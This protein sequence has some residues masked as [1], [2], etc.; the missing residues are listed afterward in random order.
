MMDFG[1]IK[2]MRWMA[3]RARKG[4]AVDAPYNGNSPDRFVRRI[5]DASNHLK[6][7]VDDNIIPGECWREAEGQLRGMVAMA[8]ATGKCSYTG[9]H[10][11]SDV[12]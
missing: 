10:L 5:A 12:E 7:M 1:Q 2:D 9:D 4:L 3:G 8:D 11:K 6:Q